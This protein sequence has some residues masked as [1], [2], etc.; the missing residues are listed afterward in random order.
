MQDNVYVL[1]R[2]FYTEVQVGCD[3]QS[4]GNDTACCL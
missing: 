4:G 1:N 2:H 3:L